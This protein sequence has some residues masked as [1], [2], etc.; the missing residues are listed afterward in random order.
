REDGSSAS[1]I[2]VRGQT[3]VSAALRDVEVEGG[4]L[5]V[6]IDFNVASEGSLTHSGDVRAV[7]R[8]VGSAAYGVQLGAGDDSSA[9]IGNVTVEGG[10]LARGVTTTYA[11]GTI[12]VTD[13]LES[14]VGIQVGDVHVLARDADSEAYG[15]YLRGEGNWALTVGNVEGEGGR[16]AR[17]VWLTTSGDQGRLSHDGNL[18]ATARDAG[19]E[20]Y[21]VHVVVGDEFSAAVGNVEASG[22]GLAR[23]VWYTGGQGG[24]VVIEGDVTA[25]SASGAAHGLLAQ[26]GGEFQ[27]SVKNVRVEAGGNAVQGVALNVG[28]GGV[29]NHE[30]LI[31]VTGTSAT[32]NARGVNVTAG[33]NFSATVGDVVVDGP[34]NALVIFWESTDGASLTHT[35]TIRATTTDATGAAG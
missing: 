33:E 8:D 27:A 4:N 21:G 29:L 30:G 11:S 26:A 31:E 3:G 17:G 25:T 19:S 7:A 18:F 14:D 32:S 15:V 35:G 13:G 9:T 10:A 2:G 5:A 6:G 34:R 28:D 16:L 24:S 22:D 20:A 1:G 23:G 12:I